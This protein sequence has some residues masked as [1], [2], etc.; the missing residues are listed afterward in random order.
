MDLFDKFGNDICKLCERKII[1]CNSI[2][3]T[4]IC[5]GRWC[6]EAHSDGLGFI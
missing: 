3:S 4:F 2:S 1:N 6:D 5:E